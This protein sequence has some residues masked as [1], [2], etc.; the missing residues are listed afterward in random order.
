MATQSVERSTELG[1]EII[2]SLVVVAGTESRKPDVSR[3]GLFR[4]E[5]A[6]KVLSGMA[7][8]VGVLI[9]WFGGPAMP[10]RDR[11]TASVV[12]AQHHRHPNVL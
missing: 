11:M 5:R 6:G 10:D 9:D 7:K 1:K 12:S 8:H 2:S 3:D 4:P